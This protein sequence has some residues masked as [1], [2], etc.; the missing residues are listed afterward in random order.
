MTYTSTD[1]IAGLVGIALIVFCARS[2]VRV[3]R[4]AKKFRDTQTPFYGERISRTVF[5]ASG[6]RVGAIGGSVVGLVLIVLAVTGQ[7]N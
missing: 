7:F 6:V 5:T 4:E 3:E 1:L 2:W